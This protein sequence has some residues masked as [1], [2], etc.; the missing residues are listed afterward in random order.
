MPGNETMA[1]ALAER[2]GAELAVLDWRRFPDLEA[3]V[4]IASDVRGKRVFIVCT[5]ANPDPQMLTLV[6]AAAA[7]RDCGAE[8]VHLVA[9]YLAYMRQDKSFRPGE[10]V[11]ATHFARMLSRHFDSLTTIDPHLHRIR[12][13]E[14]IFTIPTRVGAVAPL[15]GAWIAENVTAP[16]IVGPDQESHQWVAEI[17]RSARAPYVVARKERLG[18]EHVRIELPDLTPWSGRRPVLADDIVSSGRTMLQASRLL[19]AAGMAKPYCVAIHA[20]FSPGAFE[21]LAQ[22]TERVVTT[23]TIPHPSNAIS[24]ADTL[25]KSI[26]Y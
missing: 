19:I 14:H 10:A 4:R 22:L 23:D 3:Y 25:A 16:L 12:D 20:V 9:P 13:L 7:A 24:V 1:K 18:D 5:L 2:L 15:L 8:S 26:S 17:A 21:N 6:F 11:S